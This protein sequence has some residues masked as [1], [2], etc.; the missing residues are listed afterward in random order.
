MRSFLHQLRR[1]NVLKSM[2]TYLVAAW[3]IVQ[4]LDV[5]GPAVGMPNWVM[6]FAVLSLAIGFP[7]AGGDF[8]V[9]RTGCGRLSTRGRS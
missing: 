4:V 9:L 1:R 6:T 8:V 7:I 5:V 2:A 3:L